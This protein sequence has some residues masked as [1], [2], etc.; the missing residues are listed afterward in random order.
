MVSKD[1]SGR[2]SLHVRYVG[3]RRFAARQQLGWILTMSGHGD[4]LDPSRR[5]RTNI[6]KAN[7]ETM[8]RSY[9]IIS[10]TN[11]KECGDKQS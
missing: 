3:G 2:N 6:S 8:A 1:C 10:S 5:D 4:P 11:Y 9:L 7:E